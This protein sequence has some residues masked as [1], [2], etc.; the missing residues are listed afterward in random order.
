MK[1][2]HTK[3]TERYGAISCLGPLTEKHDGRIRPTFE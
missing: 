1:C 3:V 2:E